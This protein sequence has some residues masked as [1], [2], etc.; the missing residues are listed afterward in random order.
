MSARTYIIAAEIKLTILPEKF[1]TDEP[2]GLPTRSSQEYVLYKLNALKFYIT[3]TNTAMRNKWKER[4]YIDLQAGPGKNSIGD[5]VLLGSPLLA[6]TANHPATHFW[7]NE[8]NATNA[9]ALEQR[10]NASNLNDHVDISQADA[11]QIVQQIAQ[12]IRRRD[13][14]NREASLNIAFLD[15]EGLE[16]HWETIEHLAKVTK[17]DLIINFSTGGIV[18]SIGRGNT[19]AVDQFF[20]TSDW[21]EIYRPEDKA[22]LIQTI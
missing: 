8:Y 12:E 4:Y 16:L 9:R 18:R 5:K 22:E 19:Q 21:R 7:F 3:V 11:N 14:E 13:R 15:P 17:M 10:V 6:L 2:D 20:G 1:L